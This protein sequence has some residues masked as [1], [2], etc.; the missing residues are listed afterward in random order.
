MR[1]LL[2]ADGDE[3][4][5][6]G[7]V[8]RMLALAQAVV[9]GGGEA[10]LASARLAPGLETRLAQEALPVQHL[11]VT[12]GG[13]DDSQ[14]SLAA[15]RE[16]GA[17]WIAADGYAFGPGFQRGVSAAGRRLLLVDDFGH[18]RP[19]TAELVLDQNPGATEGLH[20]GRS[21]R[22]R[23]LLGGA[24]T[25]LRREFRTTAAP[26]EPAPLP[27]RA[28]RVLVTLGG[29]D[30]VDATSRVVAA[31]R[32]L[33]DPELRVRVVIGPGN[34]RA[35]ALS[36]A[37]DDPRFELLVAHPDMPGLMRWAEL[38]VS[39]A[40]TTAYELAT[41]GVPALLIL[42]ADNQRVVETGMAG[43][44]G[45]CASLGFHDRLAPAAIA[46]AVEALCADPGRRAAMRDAGRRCIDGRGALR[47][48]DAM[49]AF[50]AEAGP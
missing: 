4:S 27:P 33:R 7:H 43:P 23:L 16:L 6:T 37:C 21:A 9:D 48:R 30:P 49:A 22:T 19:Y 31:L 35:R 36:A 29:A 5:G 8:M 42:L 50:G 34:P 38:A 45:P 26:C 24:F 10:R 47:V 2:R 41:M 39:A 1:V 13:K 20:A 46:G 11:S 15:A 25:L 3:L 32:G 18:G 17:D 44:G 14:A 28:H 12:P 40:G